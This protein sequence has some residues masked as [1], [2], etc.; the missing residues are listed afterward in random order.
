MDALVHKDTKSWN[1]VG[2]PPGKPRLIRLGFARCGPNLLYEFGLTL[3]IPHERFKMLNFTDKAVF[4]DIV[5]EEMRKK[6]PVN[7]RKQR[8]RTALLDVGTRRRCC[9]AGRSWAKSWRQLPR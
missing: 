6:I 8:I 5:S 1:L 3:R 4:I 9:I 2:A 7:G